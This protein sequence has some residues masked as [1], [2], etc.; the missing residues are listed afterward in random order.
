MRERESM[1]GKEDD[2]QTPVGE[3]QE[4]TSTERKNIG[5]KKDDV[6]I[7]VCEQ[8]E[9][10][11][12]ERK[13]IGGKRD[14]VV[15]PVGE[16]QEQTS[17]ERKNIGGKKDD[18]VIPVCEQQQEQNPIERARMVR[19][20]FD[21]PSNMFKQ[22]SVDTPFHDQ[23]EQPSTHQQPSSSIE[24]QTAEEALLR[25]L[26]N[27]VN[28]IKKI[29]KNAQGSQT[30]IVKIQKI[31]DFI[32]RKKISNEDY[33]QPNEIAIGPIHHGDTSGQL[34]KT[35]LKH[36]LAAR[37]IHESGKTGEALL[38]EFK[39]KSN[40]YRELKKIF[41]KKVARKHEKHKLGTMLFLD[42]C[43]VLQFIDS[44]VN[45][46][47][48]ECD[49]NISICQ[50]EEI[51][52]DL[53][54]LEN[55]I[56][57][58]ALVILMR[59]S[60]KRVKLAESVYRFISMNIMAPESCYEERL[61]QNI[62]NIPKQ[63]FEGNNVPVHLL[64]LLRSELLFTELTHRSEEHSPPKQEKEEGGD[65]ANLLS[66]YYKRSYRN[67]QDLKEV[68]IVLKPDYSK[69]LRSV[70]FSSPL[71]NFGQL[72]LPPLI[73][74]ESTKQ[75]LLNLVA[76]EMCPGG[77]NKKNYAVSS[78]LR[79]LNSL[80]DSEQDVK[81]LRSAHILRN[82]LGSDQEVAELFN[83]FGSILVPH[84][85]YSSVKK[86]IQK[87]YDNKI[88]SWNAQFCRQYCRN[89]WT[90]LALLAA[91][92]AFILTGIQTYYSANPKHE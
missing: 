7:P 36:K 20:L 64:D 56:P 11:S 49:N 37:F 83:T 14:D 45:N 33:I 3:Q 92:A 57:F 19:N 89:P 15:I 9:Q 78:Y 41:E 4:Q 59:S 35:N 58:K 52:H 27:A 12:T 47:I 76:Y 24:L 8:Q 53:L 66:S 80:I 79:L 87:Y 5:G 63:L 82:H 73:V 67:V 16:Q 44:Y 1:A 21:R 75:K 69:G 38:K 17:T 18:V 29:K 46:S 85:A 84:D 13:N 72:K 62:S 55:Q 77:N 22:G 25:C 34:T 39:H 23:Q 43:S 31:P 60:N 68:G 65:S 10:T 81:D 71:F 74:D 70:S 2:V 88:V 50:V 90:I 48:L 51:R 42:G 6:V 32:R 54:L 40:K 28:K 30:K 91:L 61:K 86:D 26:D